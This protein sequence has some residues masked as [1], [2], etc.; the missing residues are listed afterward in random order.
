MEYVMTFKILLKNFKTS[1]TWHNWCQ[2]TDY[3]VNKQFFICL[4]ILSIVYLTRHYNIQPHSVISLQKILTSSIL[5][6]LQRNIL[7]HTWNARFLTISKI[8]HFCCF[9]LREHLIQQCLMILNVKVEIKDWSH[10]ILDAS[11][12]FNFNV[13]N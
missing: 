2:A 4:V 6:L 3:V 11:K 12:R 5:E 9:F 7:M 10:N 1:I 8:L 13:I